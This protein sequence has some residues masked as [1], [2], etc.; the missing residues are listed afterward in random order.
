MNKTYFD[1]CLLSD[2]WGT[3]ITDVAQLTT[4]ERWITVNNKEGRT[5]S[6]VKISA[7]GEILA[8]MGG[9]F[10]GQKINE[11]GEKPKTSR[12]LETVKSD[13]QKLRSRIT[14]KLSENQKQRDIA[15]RYIDKYNALNTKI[16][17]EFETDRVNNPSWA[18]TGR[19]NRTIKM[20]GASPLEKLGEK[21]KGLQSLE[22]EMF[23]ELQAAMTSENV[24]S[25]ATTKARNQA[26]RSLANLFASTINTPSM[27]PDIRK[28]AVKTL[29]KLSPEN[30]KSVLK[31][32]DEALIKQGSSIVKIMGTRGDA[33]K[34]LKEQGLI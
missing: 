21:A 2:Q 18:V 23:A 22:S 6:K 20:K 1:A 24:S 5:G 7:S 12:T 34:L 26:K 32:M 17:E 16:L 4:D 27:T 11:I 33:G 15:E 19:S 14:G 28:D 29:G 8:G 31:E 13:E 10:N 30:A 3:P 9:K 25:E